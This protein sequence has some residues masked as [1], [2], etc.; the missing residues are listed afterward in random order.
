MKNLNDTSNEDPER[1]KKRKIQDKK[2]VLKLEGLR[3]AAIG[4]LMWLF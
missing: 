2:N 1:E 4:I 3:I